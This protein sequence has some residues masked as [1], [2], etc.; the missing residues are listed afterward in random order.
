MFI[1]ASSFCKSLQCLIS[2]LTQGGKGDH[3]FRLI[4]SVV[5]WGGRSTANKYHWRVWGVVAVYGPHW[6]CPSSQQCELSRSTLLGVQVALQGNCPKR[7][8]YFVHFPGSGSWVLHNA[9]DSVGR[10]FC[11]LPRSEQL[12]QPGV[13]QVHCPRWAVRLNHLP[14]SSR[15]LGFPGALQE[16]H[17][18]CAVCLLWGADLRLRPSWQMSIVQDSRKTWLATGSLL[19]VWWRMQSLGPRLEQPLAFWLSRR[20]AS[21]PPVR[22]RG[23]YAVS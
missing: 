8:L 22:G 10:V 15:S 17:L 11:A 6:V 5:V 18:R 1:L 14:I 2:I 21:L 20:P 16:H 13:W 12:R 3:L 9:T 4:C 7:A 19:T 23:L